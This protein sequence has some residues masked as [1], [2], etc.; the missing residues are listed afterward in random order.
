[1]R[2]GRRIASGEF[3]SLL[4]ER[5]REGRCSGARRE[6]EARFPRKATAGGRRRSRGAGQNHLRFS[7]VSAGALPGSEYR[8]EGGAIGS[9]K[10]GTPSL[11]PPRSTLPRPRPPHEP[12]RANPDLREAD[13]CVPPSDGG[14]RPTPLRR[15]SSDQRGNDRGRSQLERAGPPA[16][17]VSINGGTHS[18]P[19]GSRAAQSHGCILGASRKRGAK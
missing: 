15:R 3:F 7:G 1:M 9:T 2:K 10:E 8:T 16:A 14:W 12:A 4:R 6:D 5:S 18:P 13:R 19:P 11:R 17:I